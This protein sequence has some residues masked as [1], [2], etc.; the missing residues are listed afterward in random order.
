MRSKTNQT[1]AKTAPERKDNLAP[2]K[3][4]KCNKT[5]HYARDCKMKEVVIATAPVKLRKGEGQST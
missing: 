5:G 4:Y 3:C 1:A 2:I